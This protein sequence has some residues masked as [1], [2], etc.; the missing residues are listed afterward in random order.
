MNEFY[1]NI[2]MQ[3]LKPLSMLTGF[4]YRS[5]IIILGRI[6]FHCAEQSLLVKRLH[7]HS[8]HHL[9]ISVVYTGNEKITLH[10]KY[11]LLLQWLG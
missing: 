4:L 11:P 2:V 6:I 10:I 8:P 1:A 9:L 5:N 3:L 7:I